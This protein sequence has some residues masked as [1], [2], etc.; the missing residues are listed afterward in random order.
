MSRFVLVH[1]AF[2]GAWIWEPLSAELEA[3]G[4]SV[5]AIDLPGAGA[6]RTP[7]AEVTLDAYAE[8]I[9]EVLAQ[10]P[11]PVVLVGHSM[12]GMAVTHAAARCPERVALLVYVAAFLPNS[13]Q[14]LIDLTKLPEGADDQVQANLVVEGDPP[15][16]TMAPEVV[17]DV[18]FGTC[19][20]ERAAWAA[21]RCGEQPL[22]PFLGP[23]EVP[24]DAVPRAYVIATQDRAIPPA[25]QRR[26]IAENPCV[27]VA[28][29]DT[30]HSPMLSATSELAAALDR[31]TA[32][33]PVP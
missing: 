26:M 5:L 10:E 4:H 24:G 9:C 19:S 2:G 8:R 13:G 17:R 14:S 22:A 31:F 18:V 11:E 29:F 16:A 20:A 12:G 6:D 30:D 25:L 23:A 7:V 1:G 27:D 15:V 28:E 3:A 32:A 33:V 21:E